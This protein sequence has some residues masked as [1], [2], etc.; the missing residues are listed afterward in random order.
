MIDLTAD[1]LIDEKSEE[2]S[3]KQIYNDSSYTSIDIQTRQMTHN[4]ENND[5]SPTH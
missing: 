2:F 4:K 1:T 3:E 5:S